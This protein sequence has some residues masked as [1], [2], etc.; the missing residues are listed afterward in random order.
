M[1]EM[2]PMIAEGK[3]RLVVD[4][5]LPMAEVGKAHQHLA[6]RGA[7]GKVILTL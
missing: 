4:Q 6:N 5:V 7:K 1:D 3:V 2:F